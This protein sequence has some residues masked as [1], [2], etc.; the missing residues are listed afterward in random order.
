MIS[1]RK[2]RNFAAA[3]AGVFTLAITLAAC[4]PP[5]S[6][7]G[8]GGDGDGGGGEVAEGCED[9]EQFIE[10]GDLDGTTV[11]VYTTITGDEA[12][13]QEASYE[14]YEECTGSTIEYEASDEFE[15]QI[16][17]RMQSGAAPD[18]A[19]IPQPGLLQR[20]VTD[21]PGVI[22]PASEEVT[23]MVDEFFTDEWKEYGTVDG[24][25]YGSPLGANAKSFVWYSP[26]MFE[27]AGYEIPTTWDDMIALSDQI[28]ADGGTPWC[29]GIASGD[30]T[31]WPAT[32]FL[33]DVVLRTAGPD[34]YD[35]WIAHEIPFNDPQIVEA[36]DAAGEILKNPE[37]VNGG[38]GDVSS[39]AT[40][41][42]DAGGFPILD[43]ECYMHRA[44]NFYGVNWQQVREDVEIAEDGDVFAFYLPSQSETEKPLLM[45]GEFTVAFDDRPE[46]NAFH[47]FVA[48]DV[49]ANAKAEVSN[50]G[51][52]SA[53]SGLDASKL[54][55][56]IDQLSN[57]LLASD[58]YTVRF[59]ASDLMPGPVGSG[60]FWTEMVNWIANDK[61]S[62][63]VL[64]SIEES[65]PTD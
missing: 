30:A 36:L 38:L 40:T 8:D 21:F 50:A 60:S 33:E 63:D 26:S 47:A 11:E 48:S 61:S 13:A 49:W 53:N 56:P 55:S 41:D 32:D 46:V 57:E 44:A 37:Y 6:D 39:I 20:L 15:A 9:Y 64:T 12:T 29:A 43:G 25:L 28:V 34:V 3:T 62:V 59:D 22:K 27:E 42:W 17:V 45:A 31:G 52:V 19:Y 2:S 54:Q 16:A 1:T 7:E 24:T 5:P 65:W 10:M 23:A 18:I 35:Q 51:W 14:K 58:E 4:T